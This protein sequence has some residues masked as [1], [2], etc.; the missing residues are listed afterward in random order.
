M[1]TDYG[2]VCV[3]IVIRMYVWKYMLS[4]I[5]IICEFLLNKVECI[6]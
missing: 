6:N 3:Y 4:G 5:I 2:V 1:E